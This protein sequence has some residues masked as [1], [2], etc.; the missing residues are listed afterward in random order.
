VTGGEA[1]V[2]V[3]RVMLLSAV[4]LAVLGVL[5]LVD[6]MPVTGRSAVLLGVVLL[7]AAAVDAVLGVKF[8]VSHT[9]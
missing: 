3:G 8:L 2:A 5:F 4:V 7:S 9:R 6:L 1:R